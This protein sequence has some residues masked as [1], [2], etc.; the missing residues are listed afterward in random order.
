MS[1]NI[2]ITRTV[3]NLI[4]T[5]ELRTLLVEILE[6]S[7]AIRFRY[8]IVNGS[9]HSEFLTISELTERGVVV[10]DETTK[11]IIRLE[12]LAEIEQFEIDAPLNNISAHNSYRLENG[13]QG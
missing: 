9:W 7:L 8:R 4:S 1:I 3:S 6:N 5:S 10:K 2:T 13:Y 11:Q 12:D